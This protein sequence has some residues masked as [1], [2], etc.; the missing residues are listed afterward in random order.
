MSVRDE[1]G[2]EVKAL[3]A[4]E[5]RGVFCMQQGPRLSIVPQALV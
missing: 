5:D 1:G 4:E 2:G 3:V